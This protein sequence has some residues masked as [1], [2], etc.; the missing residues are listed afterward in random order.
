MFQFVKKLFDGLKK[1]GCHW[2]RCIEIKGDDVEKYNVIKKKC[3]LFSKSRTIKPTSYLHAYLSKLIFKIN[4]MFIGIR[5][6]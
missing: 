1:F 3:F 6:K 5:D 4:F 2:S